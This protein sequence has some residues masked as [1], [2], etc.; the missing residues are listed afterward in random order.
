MP[1]VRELVNV[2]GFKVNENQLNKANKKVGIFK[3]N[4]GLIGTAIVGSIGAIG[5]L[6][7]KAASDMEMLTTQ[8]EVMLGSAEKADKMMEE[9]KGFAATTP[10][11][12]NDLAKGTQTL[13]SFGVAE[14]DVVDRMRMLGDTAG[15]DA[16]KLKGLILA[17]GKVQTK[18]KASMEEINMIAE[19]GIPIIGTLTQQLGVTEQEFF[20]LVSAGKI[21]RDEVTQAFRTMTSEGGM[22]F[23][24]MQKQSLTFAGLV[25]TL[26]DNITLVLAEVGNVLLP[27]LKII[28]ERLTALFQ[29]SL[30]DLIMSLVSILNPL[31][32]G[33]IDMFE[34]LL[35][36][37]VPIASSLV[38]I[39]VPVLQA[40]LQLFLDIAKPAL[41][42]IEAVFKP[43]L[44]I[45][46]LLMPIIMDVFG[47]LSD[48]I[49]DVINDVVGD[50]IPLFEELGYVIITVLKALMPILRPIIK[51]FTI[52][53][54]IFLRLN[55][56]V[57]QVI[58][59]IMIK[60]F[61]LTLKFLRP[62]INLL[63]LMKPLFEF[64]G[65]IFDSIANFLENTV[66]NIITGILNFI[67]F[68]FASI[69][70]LVDK[71]NSLKVFGQFQKLSP[72]DTKKIMDDLV[73]ESPT[74]KTNNINIQN[75]FNING[76]EDPQATK[77]AV[78]RSADALFQIKLKK[79]F[80][81][82]R[83]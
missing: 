15:G 42:L 4:M 78:G 59:K 66:L 2:I 55:L 9:L 39:L 76:A 38:N 82:S 6:A 65:K 26:K 64:I 58:F 24:G 20:K 29:G 10:F 56:L 62:I 74:E 51:I 68:I 52:L 7:V 18:G 5:A 40:V 60:G 45:I 35:D 48:L 27:T 17:F 28:V 83:I 47:I 44:E 30:G 32:E 34:M 67:N 50:L 37:L 36:V 11:A 71:L 46:E 8:F 19:R 22:F 25:S 63:E 53:L 72:I 12:L 80:I 77:R 31:L 57:F 14:E 3:K 33:A 81:E 41:M 49:L 75:D 13:L 21:G 1:T 16:E 69:N 70:K 23:Q 73:K 54:S 79:I 43:L 61:I